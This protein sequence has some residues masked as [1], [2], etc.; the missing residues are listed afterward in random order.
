MHIQSIDYEVWKIIC[1]GPKVPTK[2]IDGLL[3][4]KFESEWSSAYYKDIQGNVKAVNML[5]CALDATEF[6]RICTC[7]TAKEIW[8]KLI[9]T[10]EGTTQVKESRVSVLVHNYELFKMKLDENISQMFTRFTDIINNLKSLG[11][12]YTNAEIVRKPSDHCQKAGKTKSS[13]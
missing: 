5:Y 4:P 11:K 6:N 12:T 2:T 13:Q 7:T 8:D 1:D 10:H 3:V 9:V